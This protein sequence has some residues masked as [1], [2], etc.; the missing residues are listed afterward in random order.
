MSVMTIPYAQHVDRWQEAPIARKQGNLEYTSLRSGHAYVT[1]EAVKPHELI[2]LSWNDMTAEMRCAK[3][4]AS[5]MK[6]QLQYSE[7]PLIER[8]FVPVAF[9]LTYHNLIDAPYSRVAVNARF[10]CLATKD[11]A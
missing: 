3:W 2:V 6:L 9:L 7:Q 11:I 5:T 1:R 10:A 4:F 8:G